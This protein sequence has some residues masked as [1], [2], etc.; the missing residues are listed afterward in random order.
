M[1]HLM[2]KTSSISV[3]V[4]LYNK[5]QMSELGYTDILHTH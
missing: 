5:E 3:F 2:L 4:L 1:E